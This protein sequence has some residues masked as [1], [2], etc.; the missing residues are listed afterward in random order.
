[1]TVANY[2]QL[3]ITERLS[4]AL[5]YVELLDCPHL[6]E[7]SGINLTQRF[8]CGSIPVTAGGPRTAVAGFLPT[9][10]TALHWG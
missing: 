5:Q 3:G 6:R 7:N 10:L 8:D 4:D 2:Y 1:M 9:V